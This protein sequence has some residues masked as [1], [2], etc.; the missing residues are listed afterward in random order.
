MK[1]QIMKF[2]KRHDLIK[3][4]KTILVGVSGGPDSMALLHLLYTL[5]HTYQLTLIALG[6]DHQ[7]RGKEAQQE[8][9]YAKKTCNKWQ[10]P[11]IEEKIDVISYKKKN[12][13]SLQMAARSLRYQSYQKHFKKHSAHYLALAHHADDQI[14]TMF[15]AL[16]TITNPGALSGIPV[17]RT[18]LTGEL[19]RPLLCV[20][21][22]QIV[23]YCHSNH[24]IPQIDP[25]NKDD[26]YMRIYYRKHIVPK[27]KAKNENIH[28]TIQY[29]SE[30]LSEDERFLMDKAKAVF[31]LKQVI[32]KEPD[33][34]TVF[35]NEFKT[36]PISL[37]RR[38][39]QLI[40]D[41]LYK[42]IPK[43]LSYIHE[44]IFLSLLKEKKGNVCLDF[45]KNLQIEKA[46]DVIVLNF[47]KKKEQSYFH[48][49]IDFPTELRLPNG[50]TLALSLVDKPIYT[51]DKYTYSCSVSD[52][53]LP[54]HIRT[55]LPGD[56]MHWK[57]LNGSKK[58][59]DVFIDEKIPRSE[60]NK[61]LLVT[62]NNDTVLWIIGLKKGLPKKK[63][64]KH[65]DT[66][67][68]KMTYNEG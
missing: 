6:I 7:L 17:K 32:K 61:R 33:Q 36:Y 13:V 12:R 25:S 65:N 3:Q 48:K 35:I 19:I 59:K 28:K 40:L 8:L 37:Q 34:I 62:D 67:Y 56:R 29:L 18:F 46:Y 24:I 49:I 58:I 55:R 66:Y 51:D 1:G 5:R 53:V 64:R 54:L 15:M 20:T 11:F 60:R 50:A 41:Y 27:V 45:P 9:E 22:E 38:M 68:I 42:E 14:E 43:D 30:S 26:R 16:S 23:D 57:G 10:I 63:I 44:N 31:A 47:D 21:K 39:Y 52:I 4:G 2:I